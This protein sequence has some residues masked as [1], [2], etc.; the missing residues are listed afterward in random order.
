MTLR[1]I[2][3]PILFLVCVAIGLVFGVLVAIVLDRIERFFTRTP[4]GKE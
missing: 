3:G 4:E 2:D 1:Q